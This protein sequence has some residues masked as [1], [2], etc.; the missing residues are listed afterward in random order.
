MKI[1]DNE[2]VYDEQ[3]ITQEWLM[4]SEFKQSLNNFSHKVYNWMK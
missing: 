4:T 3:H 1:E 2:F